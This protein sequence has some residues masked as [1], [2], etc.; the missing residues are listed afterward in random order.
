MERFKHIPLNVVLVEDSSLESP[1]HDVIKQALTP[2]PFFIT[3]TDVSLVTDH[4]SID[5]IILSDFS[6]APP[7]YLSTYITTHSDA[8]L[9]V[10][11]P[12]DDPLSCLHHIVAGAQDYF[13]CERFNTSL[14]GFY[15]CL[16]F[17][18][19][20]QKRWTSIVNS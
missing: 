14:D 6:K 10:I 16:R 17:A 9:V 19:E 8:A 1:K 3:S 15:R 20:R 5:V 13:N 11:G 18:Y 12:T 7:V 2:S 4:S